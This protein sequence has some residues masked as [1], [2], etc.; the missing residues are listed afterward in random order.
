MRNFL[1]VKNTETKFGIIL[2]I[3]KHVSKGDVVFTLKGPI[4]DMPTRESIHI[5]RNNHIFDVAGKY[6]NHSFNP[7]CK[8]RGKKVIAVKNIRPFEEL[9]FN[10][11]ESEINME[12]PFLCEGKMVSGAL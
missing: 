3:N 11:N 8:I 6:M 12:C 5:G 7:S 1:Y 10:Y 4:Y 9:T 2:C